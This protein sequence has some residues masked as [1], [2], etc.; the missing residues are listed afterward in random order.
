MIMLHEQKLHIRHVL[1]LI[2]FMIIMFR[3]FIESRTGPEQVRIHAGVLLALDPESGIEYMFPDELA[4][5]VTPSSDASMQ[6][7]PDFPP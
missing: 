7:E 4:D 6:S 3:A 5:A 2:D 1:P